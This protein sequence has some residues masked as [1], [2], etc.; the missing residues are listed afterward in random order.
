ENVDIRVRGAEE[1][2]VDGEKESTRLELIVLDLSV[3]RLKRSVAD[4]EHP[5]ANDVPL[6][7]RENCLHP[8]RPDLRNRLDSVIA[9]RD[10]GGDVAGR[11]RLEGHVP[12]LQPLHEFAGLPLVVDRDVIRRVE[13]ALG[14]VAEIDMHPVG[15]DAAG[16]GSELKVDVRLEE[17][18]TIGDRIE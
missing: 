4:R 16:L 6:L 3:D 8:H 10:S 18:A 13:L 11:W 9:A 2:G 15:D 7:L 17:I 5:I 14:V 12:D 1:L